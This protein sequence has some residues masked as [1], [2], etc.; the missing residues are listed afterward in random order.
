MISLV[1]DSNK[2][3][4]VCATPESASYWFNRISK[5]FSKEWESQE[6]RSA[7]IPKQEATDAS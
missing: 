1:K 7:L 2:I 5:L 6:R 4:L 3:V